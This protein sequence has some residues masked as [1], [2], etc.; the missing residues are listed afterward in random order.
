AASLLASFC[1]RR[2]AVAAS[3]GVAPRLVVTR[4]KA[5]RRARSLIGARPQAALR[6]L[7]VPVALGGTTRGKPR[8][9][10]P[11]PSRGC[12]GRKPD[13]GGCLQRRGASGKRTP[14]RCVG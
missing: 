14:P 10:P 2:L 5:A 8:R 4:F 9:R 12:R 1:A 6:A 7:G 3:A 11:S 13:G